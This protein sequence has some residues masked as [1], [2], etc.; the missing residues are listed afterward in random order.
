M[1]FVKVDFRDNYTQ[2]VVVNMDK[3][4]WRSLR[5]VA[6]LL[7]LI[8]VS[9]FTYKLA[10]AP[11]SSVTITDGFGNPVKSLFDNI[12]ID[13]KLA[14][15]LDLGSR[16]SCSRSSWSW[17]NPSTVS[18]ASCAA[19]P[20]EGNKQAPYGIPC[21]GGCT[22]NGGQPYNIQFYYDFDAPDNYG[23]RYDGLG[24]CPADDGSGTCAC[25]PVH[26]EH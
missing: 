24:T 11:Q 23:W 4:A 12:P 14:K 19:S 1:Y 13:K 22:G 26:C 10:M 21:S 9:I 3:I 15:S 18:A 6:C 7:I 17:L 16:S 20:C 5:P 25:N 2:D 8:V